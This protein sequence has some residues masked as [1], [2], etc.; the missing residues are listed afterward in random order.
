MEEVEKM[1]E[2]GEEERR[3]KSEKNGV[4]EGEFV[5]SGV[6]LP[7]SGNLADLKPDVSTLC[8]THRCYHFQLVR[9]QIE[10]MDVFALIKLKHRVQDQSSI[11]CDPSVHLVI[12]GRFRA[13]G[14]EGDAES[15]LNKCTGAISE[16]GRN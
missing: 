3:G 9:I 1:E 4:R 16:K 11:L 2:E 10:D 15:Y 12:G 7:V 8:G 5:H 13:S 6:S 14:S